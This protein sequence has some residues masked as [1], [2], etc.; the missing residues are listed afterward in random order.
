MDDLLIVFLGKEQNIDLGDNISIVFSDGSDILEKVSKVRA[1]YVTF[2][3]E[4]DKLDKNYLPLVVK[5]I[6][7][8]FDCCF[9]NYVIE[10]DYKKDTKVLTDVHYLKDY[11]PYP[12][13]YIWSFIFRRDLLL[14]ILRNKTKIDDEYKYIDDMFKNTTAIGDIIYFH[15]PKGKRMVRNMFYEDIKRNEYLKNV[16]YVGQN[17]AGIFN[18][19]ISWIKHIG[20]CFGK[21]YDITFLYDNAQDVTLNAFKKYNI[22]CVRRSCSINY[23]CDRLLTTYSDYHYPKNIVTLEENSIFIHGNMSDYKDS[24]RY[25]NDIYS[26]Y[27][28]VAKTT[29]EKAKGYFPTKNIEY[30]INPYQLDK[31]D[32]MPHLKLVSAQR[33][34]KIKCPERIEMIAEI[35]D[36]LGIPYTWNLFTDVNENT[37]KGGLI[38]RQRTTNPL[39][40]IADADYF[41]LL[42][43]SEAMPYCVLE[44]LSVNTKVVLTPLKSYDEL[45]IKN[46]KHGIII[47]FEYFQEKNRDKLV[48]VVKKMYKEKDKT[49]NYKI[50]KNLFKGYN[51][52]FKA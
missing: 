50:N 5:K 28:A 23:V 40:Y 49:I 10:Y 16:I 46:K 4:D 39:P 41:V 44:A 14:K 13:E 30:I 47:P 36:E 34:S 18:G 43:D 1:K 35:L 3:K 25:K 22:K 29:A 42:S 12:G 33:T 7:E 26:R 17:C 15:N 48:E 37:N 11:K 38:R 24:M 20:K 19:Y 45:G 51:T 6:K 2:I 27:I 32:V 8:D 31:K 21:K 52:V 9:I